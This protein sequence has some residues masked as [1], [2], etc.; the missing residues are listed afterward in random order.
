MHTDI[1]Q[2][3]FCAEIYRENAG[4]YRYH[5]DWTP[6]LNTYRKNPFSVATLFGEWNL[7]KLLTWN[8]P[9]LGWFPLWTSSFTINTI[10]SQ[11][12][13]VATEFSQQIYA[14]TWRNSWH[15]NYPLVNK[16]TGCYGKSQVLMGKSTI[17]M[18]MFNSYVSFP[19]GIRKMLV[20]KRFPSTVGGANGGKLVLHG[21]E[22]SAGGSSR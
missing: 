12:S 4:R 19:E 11:V 6:G 7:A 17:S 2:E 8:H 16:L 18:A 5:L 9:F 10:C 22:K 3:A 20:Q 13:E 15:R 21:Y 14:T 1:S